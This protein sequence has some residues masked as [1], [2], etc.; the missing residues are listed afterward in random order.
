MKRSILVWL[1]LACVAAL[2]V[3]MFARAH[4]QD[5]RD[6]NDVKGRFDLRRVKTWG[7]HPNMGYGL[8]TYGTWTPRIVWDAGYFIVNVDTFG[9]KRFDYYAMV[10]SNGKRMEGLLFRDR[11]EKRDYVMRRFKVWRPDKR[12]VSFRFPWSS[13]RFPE[14]RRFF[15]WNAQSLYVSD[16]CPSVCIDKV[17]DGD[18]LIQTFVRAAPTPTPTP[19]V[20]PTVTPTA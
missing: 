15:R 10:R 17:P 6:P 12:T 13:V 19:T 16:N 7:S 2:L 14:K 18:A 5:P 11:K 20:T 4:H 9:N 3:P 8:V 1:A